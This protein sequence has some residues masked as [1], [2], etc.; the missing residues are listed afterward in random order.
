MIRRRPQHIASNL[1]DRFLVQLHLLCQRVASI[2]LLSYL[3]LFQQFRLAF[4][5]LLGVERAFFFF[6]YSL[7]HCRVVTNT[8]W[9]RKSL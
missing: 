5:R 7:V 4:N 6:S 2:N 9:Y 1:I 3:S 8:F